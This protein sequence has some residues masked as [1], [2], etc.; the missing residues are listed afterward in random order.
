MGAPQVIAARATT[1]QSS[2]RAPQTG[3]TVLPATAYLADV[4]QAGVS[5]YDS[6]LNVGTAGQ[7][8]V[9]VLLNTNPG[10]LE[11]TVLDKDQKPVA[12]ATVVLVPEM[13]RRQ[14]PNLYKVA[15]SDA[16]GRFTLTLLPPGLYKVIA[17]ESIQ[18]GAYQNAAFLER[19]E[20]RGVAVT[21]TAGSRSNTSV[22]LIANE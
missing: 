6:G 19:F 5:I 8:P 2:V 9:D 22:G 15:R 1:V 11:G 10:G 17:W 21:I 18:G 12:G 16:Q 14:N 7:A 4:R 13:N 3:L 20:Q